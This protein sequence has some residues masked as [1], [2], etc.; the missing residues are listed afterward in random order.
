M[1]ESLLPVD[2][3]LVE[4]LPEVWFGV[5]LFALGMYVVLDGFDFGIGMLY[6]TRTDEHERETFLAGFGPVWDANEVWLVAFGT[7]LLA[8]FPRV[9]SQLLADNY[10]LTIGFVLALLFRGL[11]PELREQRDDD[12]WRRYADYAFVGGSVFA[13][14]LLGMLAGRWLFDSATLPVVLTGVGL[15]AVS[16]VTGAAFLASK[17]G[18]DLAAELRTY[19]IGATVA[20]LGGVVVLLGTVVLTDAGGAADTILS[21]PVAAVVALSVA[22]GVGGSLLARRGKYRAWLASALALPTLLTVL[23]ALLLY[24]V[25]YPPTGLLVREAVVSPLALNLVTVLGLPVLIVVLWYFKFLYG[26]FSGP[27]KGE[28]YEG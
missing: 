17:T 10:L 28:G 2:A 11:G 8:A 27:I 22:A 12:Q 16:V 13:P 23:I 25:I 1:T 7:M 18:P 19:G 21:G 26:V 14:L 6:A 5:V 3:Y 4:S 24:P 20:Y 15:V 9:Y